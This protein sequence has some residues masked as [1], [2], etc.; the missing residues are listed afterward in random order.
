MEAERNL[1][2]PPRPVAL[3]YA[4]QLTQLQRDHEHRM[5]ALRQLQNIDAETREQLL[6]AEQGRFREALQNLGTQESP[7]P[8]P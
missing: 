4:Q 8:S 6:E 3:P 2:A 5:E 7:Q 1:P